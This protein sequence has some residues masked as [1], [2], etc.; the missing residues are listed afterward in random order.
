M[1]TPS[2]LIQQHLDA[3]FALLERHF[4]DPHF[5]VSQW[6][7]D[8]DLKVPYL[9]KILSEH[10]NMPP[11]EHLKTRRLAYAQQLLKNT[12]RPMWDIATASGFDDN[13]YF[14]RAFKAEMGMTPSEFRELHQKR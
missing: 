7:D 13:N 11:M 9:S 6:A 12:A 14:S 8:L 3:A 4:K 2:A 1:A 10:T 5:T